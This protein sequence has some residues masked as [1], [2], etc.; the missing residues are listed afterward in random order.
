LMVDRHL[1]APTE[2]G[3]YAFLPSWRC[4]RRHSA[5]PSIHLHLRHG[6]KGRRAARRFPH[7]CIARLAAETAAISQAA[8]PR[9]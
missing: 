7:H 6:R 2:A 5:P 9:Y 8:A 1:S 4:S 3:V